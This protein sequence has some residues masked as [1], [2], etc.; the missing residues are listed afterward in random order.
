VLLNCPHSFLLE[1]VLGFDEPAAAPPQREIGQPFY[2]SLFHETVA[3]FYRAWGVSFCEGESSIEDWLSRADVIVGR[4]FEAFLRQYPLAGGAVRAQQ[5]DRLRRDVHDLIRYDWPLAASGRRFVAVE[6]SFGSEAPVALPLSIGDLRLFVRGRIDRIDTDGHT[7]LVRDLKTGRPHLRVGR[8]AG[9][10][11]AID[12]QI[13]VYGMVARAHAAEW[14][15]PPDLAAAYVYLSR[16]RSDERSYRNDFHQALEPAARNWL[17]VAGDLITARLFPRTP[18]R[19]DC[20]YCAFRPVCG[21]R[22]NHRA[23][24]LLRAVILEGSGTTDEAAVR[25]LR[26]FAMLK[27]TAAAGSEEN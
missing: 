20:Q 23:E 13:A 4:T 24:S 26:A 15:T 3:E 18:D 25:P 10:T 14:E 11:S 7:T 5:H 9:P 6:R 16:G 27:L 2:G 1:H 12:L 17:D 22:A 21:E 19:D 8:E